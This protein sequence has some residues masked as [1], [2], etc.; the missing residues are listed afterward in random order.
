MRILT[1]VVPRLLN[2]HLAPLLG[3]RRFLFFVEML[4]SAPRYRKQFSRTTDD[5]G[6]VEVKDT[7][8]LV[9]VL[10]NKLRARFGEDAAFKAAYQFLFELGDAV[11]R[12]AYFSPE[13]MARDW[14]RFHQEHEAQMAEGF[15][16]NNENDGVLHSENRV[17]F[18]ITRCRFFE[19]FHDMGNAGLTEAFCRSDETVFNSYS[20]EMHFHRGST[21]P[22]TIARGANQ[23]TFIYDRTR[24]TRD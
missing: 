17:S 12:R 11:Q 2:T 21:F 7:F 19:A 6:L 23:C 14:G 5:A 8:L 22:N 1:R 13:G 24:S 16:R 10:Y 9:G 3:W 20:P 4:L 15:I 18:H